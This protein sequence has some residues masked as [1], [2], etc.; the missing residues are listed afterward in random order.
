M[1]NPRRAETGHISFKGEPAGVYIAAADALAM[2]ADLR[3]LLDDMT[4]GETDAIAALLNLLEGVG[5]TEERHVQVDR[6][7]SRD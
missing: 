5:P 3:G 6:Q 4:S 7:P 2:A 1:S